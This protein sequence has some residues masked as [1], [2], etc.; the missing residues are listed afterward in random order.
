MAD[1]ERA[2]ES[3]VFVLD[4]YRTRYPNE[5]AAHAKKSTAFRRN[6][7]TPTFAA[8]GTPGILGYG[9]IVALDTG[10]G[11]RALSSLRQF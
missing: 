3:E 9:G 11:N 1:R 5:I 6:M 2:R 4:E 10:L 7:E 8:Y